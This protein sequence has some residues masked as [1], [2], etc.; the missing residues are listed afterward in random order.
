RGNSNTW[1]T[2]VVP[3]TTSPTRTTELDLTL[4]KGVEIVTLVNSGIT[5]DILDKMA[6]WEWIEQ[7]ADAHNLSVAEVKNH[8]IAGE[9]WMFTPWRRVRFVHA[10][11][12]PLKNPVLLLKP[13]KTDIGQTFAV[14]EGNQKNPLPGTVTF[15]R[16]STARVD[17]DAAWNMPI[18]NGRDGDPET[19]Q[20][21]TAHAFGFE[22]KRIGSGFAPDPQGHV[23]TTVDAQNLTAK[24]EFHDTKY[25]AVTYRGT[26]TSYY[27]EYFRES[28][29][30]SIGL[31]PISTL[32]AG[33][34][35]PG[36]AF[37]ASTVR[38]VMNSTVGGVAQSRTLTPAPAGTPL[39]APAPTP[40]D[41]I[42]TEDPSLNGPNPD[43]ATHGTIQVLE[44]SSL[45]SP[46]AA[47]AV[48]VF[49]YVAPTIHTFSDPTTDHT[50]NL[51][52]PNSARPKAPDVLYV[53]PIYKRTA[54]RGSVTRTGGGL[55]VYLNRPWWSSGDGERLGVV[56]WHPKPTDGVLP[57][58][59]LAPY[60]TRWG[61]DPI[62][63]SAGVPKQPSP[64]C[65]PGATASRS[66]GALTIDEATTKV[67]VAGHDVH[68]DSVRGLWYC[69][70]QVTDSSGK[71][72]TSYT[73]FVKLALARYQPHSIPN[74]HLSRVVQVD[75]AQLAPNRHVTVSGSGSTRKVVVTGR[76]PRATWKHTATNKIVILIEQKDIRI[77]DDELAWDPATGSQPGF[78]NTI[79]M[80]AS[81]SG[82]SDFVTWNAAVNLPT[83]NTKP[84]R[85]AFE[86]YE[87]IDGGLGG[88]RLAYTETIL[89]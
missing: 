73:P 74:T 63:K 36:V 81:T 6:V 68:F 37:E 31:D 62:F 72:L 67:D 75:Y 80:T 34:V 22:P 45:D 33:P 61:F 29:P 17:I 2:S 13:V 78:D 71:Q 32:K 57:P 76:A 52:V 24:H 1:T 3:N 49:S 10:V 28:L 9:H 55:R 84:L 16:R 47:D 26:A 42:V 53:I 30:L 50:K 39:D 89:L 77:P 56:C 70:I 4:Q 60:V 66:D 21:F 64:A 87:R 38:L 7:Y 41:Y 19:P 58:D 18:D 12:T 65:F 20:H 69:D 11:R 14:F 25:R 59:A 46:I 51:I 27:P 5:T 86:E 85:L 8:I 23:I 43:A 54:G 83:G 88:G 79:T 82:S 15:S 48:I 35:Q 40:G 44:N